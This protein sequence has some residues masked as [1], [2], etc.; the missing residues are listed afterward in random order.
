MIG[1][2]VA[3]V[4]WSVVCRTWQETA[5]GHQPDLGAFLAG[6]Y[7]SQ[8]TSEMPRLK[9]S[10]RDSFRAGWHEAETMTAIAAREAFD[11]AEEV[12]R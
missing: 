2:D 4:R 3:L 6:W 11:G 10:F 1:L 9:S 5:A 8:L 7:M 12:S